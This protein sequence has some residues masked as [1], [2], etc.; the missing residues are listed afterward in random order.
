M[1]SSFK[2]YNVD[3]VSKHNSKED[4][5]VIVHNKVYDVT[6]YMKE[7]PG[8]ETLIFASA[9]KDVTDSFEAMVHSTKARKLLRNLQVGE[10]KSSNSLSPFSNMSLG[11][12]VGYQNMSNETLQP[13]FKYGKKVPL[14]M[15]Q[16]K[17]NISISAPMDDKKPKF[18]KF[19]LKQIEQINHNTKIFFFKIPMNYNFEMK[20]CRHVVIRFFDNFESIQRKYTPLS[21]DNGVMKL[22]IK[23]YEGG[24]MSTFI[25]NLKIGEII[26]ISQPIESFSYQKN[27]FKEIF[28]IAGGTGITPMIQV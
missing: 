10:L 19:E 12:N 5:F 9:G 26:E 27:K 11:M 24:E 3:E 15:N 2:V 8:G 21:C 6:Q 25:H 14:E 22:L 28:M 1:K 23:K 17:L 13:I 7:H 20:A 4:C 18:Y 16:Q